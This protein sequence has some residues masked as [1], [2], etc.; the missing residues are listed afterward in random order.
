MNTPQLIAAI[1]Q[2]GRDR[3]TARKWTDPNLTAQAIQARRAQLLDTAVHKLRQAADPETG[4]SAAGQAHTAALAA[5]R[6]TD[7]A[8]AVTRQHHWQRAQMLLDAGR[9]LDVLVANESDPEILAAIA[10]WGPTYLRTQQAR[11]DGVHPT[12]IDEPDTSALT[13]SIIDRLADGDPVASNRVFRDAVAART[14]NER[15]QMWASVI[16]G[17]AAGSHNPTALTALHQHDTVAYDAIA[18]VVYDRQT[19]TSQTPS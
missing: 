9:S 18:D 5:L 12:Q 3:D 10:E 19:A 15:S 7:A 6:S 14:Q 11:P 4:I 1:Q 17:T 8:K 13:N 16:D 2:F